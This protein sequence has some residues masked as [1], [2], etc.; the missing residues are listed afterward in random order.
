MKY[1]KELIIDLHNCDSTTFNRKSIKRYFFE[2]C[3]LIDMEACDLHFWDDVGVPDGE[4]QTNPRTKGTSAVQFILTSNM[5]IHTLDILKCVYV[6]IFSCK[7]FDADEATVFTAK[8]FNGD[9]VNRINERD[10]R[11]IY[12][13]NYLEAAGIVNCFMAGIQPKAVLI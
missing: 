8:Y 12:V 6:N 4:K 1:G 5:V 13:R 3:K 11:I 9:I 7:D 10:N 2:L